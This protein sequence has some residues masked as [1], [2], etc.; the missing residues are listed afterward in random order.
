M[1]HLQQLKL[2]SVNKINLLLKRFFPAE[3]LVCDELRE[4]RFQLFSWG[5]LSG[6]SVRL[7]E[8]LNI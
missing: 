8:P 5:H 4:K 3:S 6:G 7:C 1:A 2:N